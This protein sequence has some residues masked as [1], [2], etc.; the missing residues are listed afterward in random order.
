MANATNVL[1]HNND[2]EMALLG[3]MLIDNET[4]ADIVEPLKEED[5][6]G[7]SNRYV[8][9]AMKRVFGSRRP[10][11]LVTLSDQLESEG[12]L[13][14]AGGI[15]YLTELAQITPSAANYKSY[16]DIVKRD[17]LSRKLIRASQKIIEA[18]ASFHRRKATLAFCRKKYLRYFPAD[19]PFVAERHAGRKRGG[20]RAE[21]IRIAFPRQERVPRRGNGFRR[22][23]QL[24]NGLQKSDL[25]VLAA[26]P[27]VGKTSFSMNIVEHAAMCNHKV[28]AV[29]SLEMPRAQIVQ[30]L[31]CSYANVSMAKAL[32]GE[33]SAPDWKK[34]IDAAERLKDAPIYVDDSSRTTPSEIESK[35]RRLK[36]KTGALDLIM[37]DYIQLM[38]GG[39]S[40]L[41]GAEN[42]QQEIASITRDLKII[43]KELEVP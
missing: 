39:D 26:R 32:S 23:D 24:T 27:G 13:E 35:C 40:K 30:R 41:A 33:L 7:E 5:F 36:A 15:A 10:I 34:L 17:S 8:L 11:D 6:Y 4:A 25:I 1:P 42:R 20:R 9:S 28:C 2:A 3:C 14:K 21:E 38:S 16:F 18:C 29:F 31:L 43:A 19:R 22:F 12:N 37:I